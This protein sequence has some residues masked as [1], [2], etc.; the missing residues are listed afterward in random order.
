VTIDGTPTTIEGQPSCIDSG[1]QV[2]LAAGD[3]GT[4]GLAVVL[5]TS[6]ALEVE[7]VS[8]FVNK[9]PL[10]YAKAAMGDAQAV[11]DGR[12]YTISGNGIAVDLTNPTAGISMKPFKVEVTCP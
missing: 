3:T 5:S 7:S 9:Q 8:I 4:N 12:T 10:T 2:T 6:E 11:K 1:G